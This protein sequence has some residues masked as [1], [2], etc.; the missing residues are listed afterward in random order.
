MIIHITLI[1]T[2][3]HDT[4][5]FKK[6]LRFIRFLPLPLDYNVFTNGKI[7]ISRVVLVVYIDDLLIT[8][9]NEKDI[10]HIK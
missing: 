9:K 4:Y 1:L 7:I 3:N 8:G 6:F 5:G 10:L 2:Q